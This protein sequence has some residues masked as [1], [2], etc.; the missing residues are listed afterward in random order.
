MPTLSPTTSRTSDLNTSKTSGST[1]TSSVGSSA[2]T[3]PRVASHGGYGSQVQQLA[4]GGDDLTSLTL[5]GVTLTAHPSGTALA[6]VE[7]ALGE[8][9]TRAARKASSDG[10]SAVLSLLAPHL[11]AAALRLPLVHDIADAYASWARGQVEAEKKVASKG[12]AGTK[13][14][15]S[16]GGKLGKGT[17]ATIDGGSHGL[18]VPLEAAIGEALGLLAPT[19]GKSVA[20]HASGAVSV[21]GL[22]LG[23]GFDLEAEHEEDGFAIEGTAKMEIGLG[24][25]GDHA[26]IV[27]TVKVKGHG[28]DAVEAMHMVGLAVEHFL[29]EQQFDWAHPSFGEAW[30]AGKKFL[31][32]AV[33][34]DA[35]GP[36][37]GMAAG[38]LLLA[39]AKIA[40]ALWG[41]GYEDA[42]VAQM[43]EDDYGE[44]QIGVGVGGKMG[45][46]DVD[47]GANLDYAHHTRV[48][49]VGGK[50]GSETS[51]TL[52]GS[53]A[54]GVE[55]GGF[56]L[57]VSGHMDVPTSG[58]AAD[59]GL[60]IAVSRKSS[61]LGVGE[62]VASLAKNAVLGLGQRAEKRAG[63][64]VGRIAAAVERAFLAA[65][66]LKALSGRCGG[67]A[68]EAEYDYAKGE[69]GLAVK[70]TKAWSFEAGDG[71]E[72]AVDLAFEVGDEVFSTTAEVGQP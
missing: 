48:S 63:G 11:P 6:A 58:D 7:R 9:W 53:F 8:D 4:P 62:V 67:I 66:V 16:G 42:I 50:I 3:R 65:E 21:E 52:S 56:A 20:A 31:V 25:V 60:E 59:V 51:D 57:E 71:Q 12:S 13:L 40:D 34:F 24:S 44:H 46:D 26:A 41:K 64:W 70:V 15:P 45:A 5:G 22:Y 61:E 39:G 69:L 38:A 17:A 35:A 2:S 1:S 33:A 49:N 18:M 36:A 43:D 10:G 37:G 47:V 27:E 55:G 32:N 29:R 14:A 54:I 68:L 19:P 28:D 23:M 72:A 30:R